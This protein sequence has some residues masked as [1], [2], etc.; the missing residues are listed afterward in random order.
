MCQSAEAV[1]ALLGQLKEA[2]FKLL[3][4]YVVDVANILRAGTAKVQ[5]FQ[6]SSLPKVRPVCNEPTLSLFSALPSIFA[7]LMNA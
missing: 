4:S 5:G 7:L 3:L 1:L 2:P 6:L